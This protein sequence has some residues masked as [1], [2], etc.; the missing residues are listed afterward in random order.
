MQPVSIIFE[1]DVTISAALLDQLALRPYAVSVETA[2]VVNV[3]ITANRIRMFLTPIAVAYAG[4]FVVTGLMT[5]DFA[6]YMPGMD[7]S[8]SQ[9]SITI[10]VN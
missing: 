2:S 9:P 3:S 7:F 8:S 1:G 10:S 4:R 6:A 5:A